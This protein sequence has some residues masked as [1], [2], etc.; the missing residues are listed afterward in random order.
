VDIP[1]NYSY[2]KK[3]LN[4]YS[5]SQNNA[6]AILNTVFDLIDDPAYKPFFYKQ[7]Y[8]VGATQFLAA[9]D[10]ARKNGID[11]SRYFVK[12]LKAAK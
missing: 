4:N 7:L 12:L 6:D 11:K 9:A 10:H 2:S 3:V 1:E 5:Y 8:R